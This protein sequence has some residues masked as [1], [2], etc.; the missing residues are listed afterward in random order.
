M[1]GRPPATAEPGGRDGRDRPVTLD[2]GDFGDLGDRGERGERGAARVDRLTVPGARRRG[3]PLPDAHALLRGVASLA[4]GLLVVAAAAP[5]PREVPSAADVR[6]RLA[7]GPLVPATLDVLTVTAEIENAAPFPVT[8]R[9]ARLP[10]DPSAGLLP[11]PLTVPAAGSASVRLPARPDCAAGG[12]Q[13]LQL[14]LAAAGGTR[15]V[16]TPVG[17]VE[18]YARL[19]PPTEPGLHAAVT[20]TQPDATGS[21][22][23]VRVVNRGTVPLTVGLP[24]PG[25][26]QRSR[27]VIE[28]G[29][30]LT[31]AEL[32]G[33]APPPP[34]AVVGF[35][36]LPVVLDAGAA[37]VLTLRPVADP[38]TPDLAAMT[39]TVRAFRPPGDRTRR[40][41][42]RGSQASVPVEGSDVLAAALLASARVLCDQRTS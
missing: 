6:V 28:S 16:R 42:P 25:R 13:S 36:P 21:Q 34:P 5:Q 27:S 20:G 30:G 1:T 4:A 24:G 37:V 15:A 7:A 3:T 38:C 22:A 32:N 10:G 14:T 19:C 41:Q 31:L 33:A 18:A 35:P 26:Q 12:T 17:V 8:V 2:L 29:T 40:G 23:Q 11:R 39:P 9:A